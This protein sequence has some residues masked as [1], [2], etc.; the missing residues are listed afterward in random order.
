M[1]NRKLRRAGRRASNRVGAHDVVIAA[2]VS[3]VGGYG[4]RCLCFL[5]PFNNGAFEVPKVEY[6]IVG[7]LVTPLAGLLMT[8]LFAVMKPAALVTAFAPMINAV[9]SWPSFG[10][11]SSSAPVLTEYLHQPF[12]RSVGLAVFDQPHAR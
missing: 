8:Q 1:G 5:S 9:L 11:S 10:K 3:S 6:A 4:R 7:Q 12:V 2:P